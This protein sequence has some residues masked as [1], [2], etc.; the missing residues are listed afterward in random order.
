M[1]EKFGVPVKD[2]DLIITTIAQNKKVMQITL[3]GSRAKGNYKNGSDIDLAIKAPG[4]SITD[5]NE[6]TINIED[7]NLPYYIDII[8]IEHINNQNL[9]DHIRR[10]GKVVYTVTV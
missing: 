8:D 9:V 7:L 3:F 1:T 10:I 2:F 6:I 5:L 4:I